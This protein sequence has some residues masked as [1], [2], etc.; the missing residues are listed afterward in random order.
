MLFHKTAIQ[1]DNLVQG[2]R[3][4]AS[5][6]DGEQDGEAAVIQFCDDPI[7]IKLLLGVR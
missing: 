4:L 3:F 5:V 6:Y 1:G 7:L 2:K